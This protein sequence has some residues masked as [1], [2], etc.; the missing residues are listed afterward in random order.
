MSH[1]NIHPDEI[2]MNKI[3]FIRNQKV[4]L[5]D[6]LSELYGVETKRLNEQVKRNIDRF[7]E[8]FMFQLNDE[9]FNDLKS[10][11]ATSSWGGRRKPPFAFTEHG[12]LMLSSVL[13]SKL[14]I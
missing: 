4:M 7:P 14:A 12:V 3:Y 9:E 6:D 13:N 10:Q 2:V 8:D 5:D 1:N 11:I